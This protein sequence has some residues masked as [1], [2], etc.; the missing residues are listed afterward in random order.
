[1]SLMIKDLDV[2]D[3]TILLK[4]KA[5]LLFRRILLNEAEPESRV[6]QFWYL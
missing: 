2:F 6:A 3:P 1:M 4:N 5:H